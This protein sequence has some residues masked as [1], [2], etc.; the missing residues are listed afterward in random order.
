LHT[1]EVGDKVASRHAQKTTIG[2]IIPTADMPTLPDGSVIDL[3]MN[4]A[5]IPSRM[6]IG[7][8]IEMI[9]SKYAVL[10][11]EI[12]N[13]GAWQGF[14]MDEVVRTLKQYGFTNKLQFDTVFNPF[15]GKYESADIY[16][17]P[18]YYQVLPHIARYKIQARS[19]GAMDRHTHQPVA[20]RSRHGGIR[21]GYMEKDA[22]ITHGAVH[23][24]WDRLCSAGGEHKAVIC[25]RCKNVIDVYNNVSEFECSTC[26]SDDVGTV[27]IPYA[28]RYNNAYIMAAGLKPMYGVK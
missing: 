9:V 1:L 8:L 21:T 5:A 16:V 24:V 3:I 26:G 25:K 10:K 11:G 18:C 23:T 15:T 19:T 6:T 7:Q 20:G 17:G 13:G 14:D 2:R 4:P 27:N 12:I 28:L 22:L